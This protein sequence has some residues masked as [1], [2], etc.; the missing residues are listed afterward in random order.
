MGSSFVN[1]GTFLL[2]KLCFEDALDTL[3]SPSVADDSE[4]LHPL[5]EIWKR[6]IAA[7]SL[8]AARQA[9]EVRLTSCEESQAR[10]VLQLL[11]KA[12]RGSPLYVQ[13]SIE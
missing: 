9:C 13:S 5:A 3:N 2:M 6:S 12:L 10:V 11:W 7:S 4:H 8:Y 1:F